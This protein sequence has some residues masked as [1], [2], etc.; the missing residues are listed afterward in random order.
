[1]PNAIGHS[2]TIH[3][4]NGLENTVKYLGWMSFRVFWHKAVRIVEGVDW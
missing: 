2:P 3:V 1:V 4:L